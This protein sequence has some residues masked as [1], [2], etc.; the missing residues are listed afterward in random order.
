LSKIEEQILGLDYMN[1][2]LG[3]RRATSRRSSYL[4]S[5]QPLHMI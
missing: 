4:K 3:C 2:T 5:W 1:K